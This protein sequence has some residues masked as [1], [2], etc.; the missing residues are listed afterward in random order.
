MEGFFTNRTVQLELVF[1]SDNEVRKREEILLEAFG[2]LNLGARFEDDGT[3]QKTENNQQDRTD[4]SNVDLENSFGL[5]EVSGKL[6]QMQEK[7]RGMS[8]SC[9]LCFLCSNCNT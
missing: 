7:V 2:S 9:V 4:V 3:P 8:K 5:E 6:K 1:R